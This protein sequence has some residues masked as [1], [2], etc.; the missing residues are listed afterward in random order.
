MDLLPERVT[1][2]KEY[3]VVV[4]VFF[5]FLSVVHADGTLSSPGPC[6]TFLRPCP[7]SESVRAPH[8]HSARRSLTTTLSS[9]K[10]VSL[11]GHSLCPNVPVSHAAAGTCATP[12]LARQE[13]CFGHRRGAC[14]TGADTVDS[15]LAAAHVTASLAALRPATHSIAVPCAVPR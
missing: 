15:S 12:V 10:C 8:G 4:L 11:S 1:A 5:C 3:V 9:Q 7:L 13:L 2:R 6:R 14:L